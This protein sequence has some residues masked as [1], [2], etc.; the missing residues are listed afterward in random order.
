MAGND[1]ERYEHGW[2]QNELRH[3]MGTETVLFRA[4]VLTVSCSDF[5]KFGTARHGM[6]KALDTVWNG[7]GTRHDTKWNG[8]HGTTQ[9]GHGS[10]DTGSTDDTGRHG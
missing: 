1:T 7:T 5:R 8:G 6:V 3:S 2:K 9:N 4:C 10:N